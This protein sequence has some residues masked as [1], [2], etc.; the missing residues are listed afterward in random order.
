VVCTCLEPTQLVVAFA[1]HHIALGAQEVH[2]FLD[3]PQPDLEQILDRIP[4]VI[5]RVC[6]ANYWSNH[7]RGRRPRGVEFRQLVNAY[8]AYAASGMDWLAHLDADEFIHADFAVG[9]ILSA[10]PENIHYVLAPPRERV[11]LQGVPQQTLFD[12][13]FRCPTPQDWP[14]PTGVYGAAERF[15]RAGVLS[16][17]HGKSFFRTTTDLLPGIH[18]PRRRAENHTDPLNGLLAQRMRLLHF[19]GL[20][21]LHWSG[22]L[23]RA[24]QDGNH[25]HYDNQ[26]PRNRHRARQMRRMQQSGADMQTAWNMHQLLKCIPQDK[27]DQ[28]RMLGLLEDYT[29]NPGRDI[30]LLGLDL[31]I[32]LGRGAFDRALQHQTPQVAEWVEEWENVLAGD[33]L[34]RVGT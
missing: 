15:L 9:D 25:M 3:A 1:A 4:E 21:A 31:D 29:L 22:K 11:F 32:D 17:P 16:H 33:N 30:A 2:L 5:Y 27:V 24:A 7:A 6:D 28:F 26:N 23:L 13:S 19:D 14:E 18:T 12:G 8:H 34:R 10:Q 20:T